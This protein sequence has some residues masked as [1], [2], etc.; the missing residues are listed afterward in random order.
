MV[1]S[2]PIF[3]SECERGYLQMNLTATVKRASLI[4]KDVSALM[5]TKLGPPLRVFHPLPY[6][7]CWLLKGRKRKQRLEA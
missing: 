4:M 7:D 5:F 1:N 6:V 3:T 2:V